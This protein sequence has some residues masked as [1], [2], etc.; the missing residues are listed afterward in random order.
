VPGNL[1]FSF[2]VENFFRFPFESLARQIV[3][4]THNSGHAYIQCG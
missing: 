3:D 4:S 1:L 2:A